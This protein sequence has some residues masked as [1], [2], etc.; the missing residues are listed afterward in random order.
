[1]LQSFTRGG[2]LKRWLSRDDCP[3]AVK[4][5]KALFDRSYPQNVDANG[6]G[7]ADEEMETYVSEVQKKP[8][9]TPTDLLALIG[10][11]RVVLHARFKSLGVVY[12]RS[13][14]H[15]GNSLVCFYPCG[16]MA[17]AP[18]PGSIKY[19]FSSGAEVC[20][21]V[22]RQLPRDPGDGVV[23]Q[24][25]PYP[26]FGA[27]LYQS[28]LGESLEKVKLDWICCHFARWNMTTNHAVVLPL[29]KVSLAQIR[30]LHH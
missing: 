26:H 20:F 4:E 28:R 9:A 17:S 25:L 24:F 12:S 19:I 18:I 7:D 2:K 27:K 8:Q 13:S 6:I 5:C 10:S 22:Q 1:M 21:A 11:Q 14:T 29:S 15:L 23:D 3:E 30:S 16:D